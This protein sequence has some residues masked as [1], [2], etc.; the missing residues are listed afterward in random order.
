M[1]LFVQPHR[2]HWLVGGRNSRGPSW[3][4]KSWSYLPLH[5]GGPVQKIEGWRQVSSSKLLTALFGNGGFQ[6]L[7]RGPSRVLSGSADADKANVFSRRLVQQWRCHRQ[8]DQRRILVA[9]QAGGRH[10]VL[11]KSAADAAQLLGRM[12]SRWVEVRTEICCEHKNTHISVKLEWFR[13]YDKFDIIDIIFILFQ[14]AGARPISTEGPTAV[15]GEALIC[16]LTPTNRST[17]P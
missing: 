12:L 13:D 7:V 6:I 17:E 11:R 9:I 10:Y 14:T 4:W 15:S 2:Q 3:G 8:G 1:F 16:N 5:L